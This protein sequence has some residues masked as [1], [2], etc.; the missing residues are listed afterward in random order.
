[1]LGTLAPGTL[2]PWHLGTLAQSTAVLL[3]V[4]M[5]Y[6]CATWTCSK[7]LATRY[8]ELTHGEDSA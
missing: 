2:A 1:M 8:T 5:A 3:Q 6:A 7:H 4:T